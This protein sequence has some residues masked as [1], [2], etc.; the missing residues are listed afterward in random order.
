MAGPPP[1]RADLIV[2]VLHGVDVA[3]PY[4]WLEAGDDPDVGAWVQAQNQHTR[5]LLDMAPGRD[6]LHRRLTA[7][8]SVGTVHAP[9]VAGARVF[10]LDRWGELE[11]AVLVH[12][13]L[14]GGEATTLVDPHR[15]TGDDTAA[16]DW[17]APSRDGALVAYGISTGGS[18]HSVLGIIDVE[19]GAE[20]DDRIPDTRAASVAW[21]AD[22]SGFAYTRYPSAA[23]VGPEESQYH[24]AVWWHDL[25]TDPTNDRPVFTEFPDKTAW[26]NV[27]SSV[28]G[29]WLLVSVSMG[30][31]RTDVHLLDLD[32]D[33]SV[34]LIGGIDAQT[35][36]GIVD[37]RLLGVTTLDAPRGRVIE[38]SLDSPLARH[39]KTLIPE[40]DAVIDAVEQVGSSL[41]V[42]ST[43]AGVSTLHRHELDGTPIAPIDFPS[44]GS[45][46]G[47]S[48]HDTD[49]VAVFGYT[50]FARPAALLLWEQGELGPFAD[51]SDGIDGAALAVD[52]VEYPSLDGTMV[53]MF[54]VRAADTTPGPETPTVLSGYGGFAISS[55]PAFNP[56]LVSWCL[57]GGTWAVAGLRG[58]AE[59]GEDWHRAGMRENKQNVFDDFIAAA[60]WLVAQG[61]TSRDRLAVRG[62]SNGGLLVGAALTQ[63]PDLCRAVHCAVPLLDMVRYHRFLIAR[64]WIPE[65]GDPDVAEEFAWLHA[66][67]PYHRA[68]DQTCYPA[69]LITTAEEDS[70]VDP[71][72]A[73]KMAARLQAATSCGDDRPVLLRIEERAGHGQGKPVSKQADELVDVLTFFD[74]QLRS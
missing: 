51:R 69:T 67:S 3:D 65:Y 44:L 28:D 70:R 6:R 7:L 8:L 26:P 61:H 20:L 45:I 18:E 23:D 34:T 30:W 33:T 14:A 1:T 59:H 32:A 37:G 31:S 64:L 60:D 38:A 52:Q 40:S 27:T 47:L 72:H 22:G 42:A 2:D 21:N 29:R 57:D 53:S 10:S 4:R 12:R 39:W 66:Y 19:T 62:G 68:T 36:L 41:F 46:S 73:R 16:I 35:S 9:T 55:A 13:P 71:L 17:Y 56:A 50:S 58:G 24:R 63:R 74:S 5:Q 15:S 43:S 49:D 48:A 11:Q 54:I 25:G